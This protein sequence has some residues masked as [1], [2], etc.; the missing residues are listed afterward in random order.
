[1]T[2][3]AV[4]KTFLCIS[5][6]ISLPLPDDFSVCDLA[7]EMRRMAPRLRIDSGVRASWVPICSGERPC[8]ASLAKVTSSATFH[9][10][11]DILSRTFLLRLEK[12]CDVWAGM[13]LDKVSRGIGEVALL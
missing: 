1:M 3:V 5:Q 11:W 6:S 7:K 10:R 8:R 12:L 13:N 9:G 4:G 2:Y